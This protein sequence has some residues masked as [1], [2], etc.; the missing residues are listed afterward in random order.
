F[1]TTYQTHS[2]PPLPPTCILLPPSQ[3]PSSLTLQVFT[4]S[5]PSQFNKKMELSYL[6]KNKL[7]HK[8]GEVDVVGCKKK[9]EMK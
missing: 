4:I 5:P 2:R 6:E 9:K 7:K 8:R 3:P 1:L